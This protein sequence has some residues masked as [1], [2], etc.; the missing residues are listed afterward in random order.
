[1]SS[2]FRHFD[3][4]V[5]FMLL[6]PDGCVR[7]RCRDSLRVVENF[8]RIVFDLLPSGDERG[9]N[10]VAGEEGAAG[11]GCTEGLVVDLLQGGEVE[12]RIG[13]RLVHEVESACHR[14]VLHPVEGDV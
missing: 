6:P 2:Y 11:F 10:L 4:P 12:V 9:V 8:R 5:R 14:M 1:M 13:C 7:N 3:G